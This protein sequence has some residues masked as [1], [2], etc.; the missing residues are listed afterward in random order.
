MD[1]FSTTSLR[2]DLRGKTVRGG[3]ASAAG[4]AAQAVVSLLSV[5]VLSRLL[6]ESDFGLIAMVTVVTGFATRFVDA[7]LSMATVQKED[8]TR[9]QASN[10][11]WVATALGLTIG[12]I[13]A[14]LGPVLAMVYGEPKLTLITLAMAVSFPLG[15]LSVQHRALLRRGMRLHRLATALVIAQIVG[16]AA[17]IAWAWWRQGDPSAYWALVLQPVVRDASQVVLMW[18]FCG[19]SPNR[20]RRGAGT[21]GLVRFGADLTASGTINYFVGSADRAL[22][23]WRWGE[24]AL[25]FY[26]VAFRLFVA[27]LRSINTPLTSVMTPALSRLAG[28]PDRY[29]RYYVEVIRLIALLS[30]PGIA[31]I[32]YEAELFVSI[33]LGERWG[34]SAPILRAFTFVGAAQAIGNTFG[35]LYVSQGRSSDMLRWSAMAV[36][37]QVASFVVGLPYGPVGVAT[38]YAATSL[39]ITLPIHILYVCRK[40][41]I[42]SRDIFTA[43]LPALGVA[44]C[45]LA[46]VAAGQAVAEPATPAARAAWSL[47]LAFVGAAI[48]TSAIPDA[49]RSA[50]RF[51]RVLRDG[52]R[53]GRLPNAADANG[54]SEPAASNRGVTP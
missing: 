19:W 31:W 12:L 1:Y 26:D 35:W 14:A 49:R 45:G 33:V 8:I 54:E 44:A 52:L 39:C 9:Q 51:L 16:V 40:G 23:G 25:G 38:A 6:D 29:R 22:V 24:A 32:G 50:G 2:Q 53:R 47:L 42:A 4:Q 36:P 30:V 34:P 18:W 37:I 5:I 41:P 17:A 28:E 11:F 27:P 43:F 20:P 10:L 3:F 13:V 21:W 7:G 48:A 46:A 15:G